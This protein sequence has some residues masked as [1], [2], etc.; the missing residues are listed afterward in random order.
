MT[1]NDNQSFEE[2]WSH[3]LKHFVSNAPLPM[4]NVQYNWYNE[5]AIVT[6]L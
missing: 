6:N 4:D 3:L 1:A 5:S 2:E